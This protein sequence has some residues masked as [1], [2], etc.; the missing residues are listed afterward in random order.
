MQHGESHVSHTHRVLVALILALGLVMAAGLL[1]R[2]MVQVFRI[3]HQDQRVTVTGSATRR[4]KSD[5]IVWRARVHAQ[6]PELT[7]AY[8]KLESDVPAVLAFLK[9][10]GVDEK[11]YTVSS[12]TIGEVHP[13]DKEGHVLTET[14]VGYTMEQTV[15]VS[16]SDI[17]KVSKVSREATELI[18]R[19]IF[20]HSEAPLYIYTK[21]AE[22]KIQMLAE[23][24]K[25]ARQRAEQI[26]NN[27][28]GR[29][30]SLVTARMGV[31][32]IN[33]AHSTEV[34]A[35]GNNDKSS[36]DK[37]VMA[38]VTASFAVD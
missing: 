8:K 24:S 26:T 14:V 31:M 5:F 28:G 1:G 35:E 10:H 36:L 25:D 21:L 19:G 30:S 33:P 11:L 32:Q 27:A 15:E 2:A 34:S 4:I 17:D 13:H 7:Q 3:R 20:I 9:S 18:E 23:A 6:A 29:V 16:G 12:V 38:V 22:L 37:D